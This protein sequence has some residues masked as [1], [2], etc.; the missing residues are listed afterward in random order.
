M[1]M[2]SKFLY[3]NQLVSECECEC[4]CVEQIYS[5]QSIQYQMIL[6]CVFGDWAHACMWTQPN[7]LTAF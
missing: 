4:V 6:R 2:R 7:L 1:S 3:D 5:I